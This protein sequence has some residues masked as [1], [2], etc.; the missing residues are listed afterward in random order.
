M[1]S[2]ALEYACLINN[3]IIVE[4]ILNMKITPKK[5]HFDVLL[6]RNNSKY[7]EHKC[8]IINNDPCFNALLR[9]GY[10]I[11]QSDFENLLKQHLH[12]F[13]FSHSIT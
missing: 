8:T 1:N 4:T 13:L 9:A 5:N 7:F 2:L 6:F 11:T 12:L 3:P 10:N